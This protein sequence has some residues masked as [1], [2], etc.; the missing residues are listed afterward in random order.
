M[1]LN[2]HGQLLHREVFIEHSKEVEL[3]SPSGEGGE[4]SQPPLHEINIATL[5][6]YAFRDAQIIEDELTIS[7][8]ALARTLQLISVGQGID[9]IEGELT[10]VQRASLDIRNAFALAAEAGSCLP[11]TFDVKDSLHPRK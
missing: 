2:E 9:I 10:C 11:R 4:S 7:R 1:Y 3:A 5:G 6:K 8:K